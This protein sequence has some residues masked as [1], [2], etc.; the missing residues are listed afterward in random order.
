M[1]VRIISG[2]F[3]GRKIDAPSGRRTHPMGERI[4]NAI[5]NSL[6]SQLDGAV[7]LDAFAGSGAVGI[8]ALSRGARDVVFV[9]RDR[10]AQNIIA[11]NI[12]SLGLQSRSQLIRTTVANWMDR[13]ESSE[14]D[15]IFEVGS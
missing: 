13:K 5:F 9:E 10:I 15:I 14:F 1:N 6:S 4:R 12:T 11:K 7:V 8:E 2:K 3:G